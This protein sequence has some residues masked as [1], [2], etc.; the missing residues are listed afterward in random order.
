[1]CLFGLPKKQIIEVYLTTKIS[2]V[3]VEEHEVISVKSKLNTSI[4]QQL[5]LFVAVGPYKSRQIRLLLATVVVL[6]LM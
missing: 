1:M 5:R 3:G 4:Y 2:I 6:S